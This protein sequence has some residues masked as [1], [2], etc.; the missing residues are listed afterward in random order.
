LG[1]VEELGGLGRFKD[2]KDD[3]V[4]DA[5]DE[6]VDGVGVGGEERH[7]ATVG[8]VDARQGVRAVDGVVGAGQGAGAGVGVETALY[9]FDGGHCDF[10]WCD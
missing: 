9:G 5:G 6:G 4:G 1:G 7:G 2:L 3:A 8:A 10:L